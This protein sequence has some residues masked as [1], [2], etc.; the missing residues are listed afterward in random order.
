MLELFLFLSWHLDLKVAGEIQDAP[1]SCPII[2]VSDTI[3]AR[4]FRFW[5][6]INANL[7]GPDFDI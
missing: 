2:F 7:N 4:G 3:Q 5:P 6:I 1:I